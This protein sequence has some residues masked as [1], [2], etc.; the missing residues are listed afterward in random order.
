L[1][2][3]W[4]YRDHQYDDCHDD[5]ALHVSKRCPFHCFISFIGL[6]SV[7]GA[8]LRRKG[9]SSSLLGDAALQF[10]YLS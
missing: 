2:C 7:S 8:E 1:C 10:L 6:F 3:N 9:K 4:N 5:P